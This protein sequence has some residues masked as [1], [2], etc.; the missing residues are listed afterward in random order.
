MTDYRVRV[1][2]V[3]REISCR[4]DQSVLDACLRA[5]VWL[6]HSCTHG[7]CGTC[8]AAVTSGEVDHHDSSPFALL[9]FER[10][11][12]AALL[13]TATPRADLV[14][15]ADV[16]AEEGVVLHPVR[17]LGGTVAAVEDAAPRVRRVLID[18]DEALEFNPGQYVALRVPGTTAT[19]SYSLANPPSQ[20]RR[21]E[22]HIKLTPGGRCT[23]G[24]VFAS[25]ATGDRVQ[26]SGP[27][28]QFF[29]RPARQE[30]LLMVAAGTGLAPLTSMIRHLDEAGA[31]VPVTL[32]HG[33]ATRR[34]LYDHDLLTRWQAADPLR[35]HYRPALSREAWDGRSGRVTDRLAADFE[36]CSGNVAYVCGPPAMVEDTLRVLMRKRLFPRDIYREH[37]YDE[38][39]KS[40]SAIRSP[41]LRR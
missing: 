4:A 36:R 16:E 17:D 1:E 5:G 27:Y 26:L 18:T 22:L 35:R 33:A 20:A 6:P 21:L 3:G 31:Q 23:E 37:Y 15:E 24:W 8:K 19:R 11:E 41:L 13:C 38:S 28:G 40:A 39:H 25:L 14:V 7:T 29:L 30:P 12:G 9:D 34:D 10:D 32:Y 2:P